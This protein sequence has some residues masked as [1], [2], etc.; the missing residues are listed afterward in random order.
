MNVNPLNTIPSQ[1][2]AT[3]GSESG[4]IRYRGRAGPGPV[5]VPQD[6]AA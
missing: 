4:Q 6:V 1:N 2:T 3:R 5:V